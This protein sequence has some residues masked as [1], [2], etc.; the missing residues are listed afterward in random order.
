V[1][2]VNPNIPLAR[3]NRLEAVLSRIKN[4]TPSDCYLILAGTGAI[5]PAQTSSSILLYT[6]PEN[7]YLCLDKPNPQGKEEKTLGVGLVLERQ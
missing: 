3:F 4:V 5:T 6:C 7:L 2:G 1:Q